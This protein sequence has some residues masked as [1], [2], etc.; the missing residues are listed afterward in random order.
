[1]NRKWFYVLSSILAAALAAAIILAVTFQNTGQDL[2]NSVSIIEHFR[3]DSESI[4]FGTDIPYGSTLEEHQAAFEKWGDTAMDADRRARCPEGFIPLTPQEQSLLNETDH[5]T[6]DMLLGD[7]GDEGPLIT[8]NIETGRRVNESYAMLLCRTAFRY[9]RK[10]AYMENGTDWGGGIAPSDRCPKGMAGRTGIGNPEYIQMLYMYTFGYVPDGL[11]DMERISETCNEI[12]PSE[13]KTGDIAILELE[14]S[15]KDF[16]VCIGAYNGYFLFAHCV[17]TADSSFPNG[18][19]RIC[20]MASQTDSYYRGSK[21]TDFTGFY[22]SP[23]RFWGN[24][25]NDGSTGEHPDQRILINISE[26]PHGND[27]V[28][29]YADTMAHELASGS[30]D[31]FLSDLACKELI[32]YGYEYTDEN[33]YRQYLDKMYE[34]IHDRD[35]LYVAF[36][37]DRDDHYN[38]AIYGLDYAGSSKDTAYDYGSRAIIYFTIFYDKE[39]GFTMLPYNAGT[40]G[41]N[42]SQYGLSC[43]PQQDTNAPDNL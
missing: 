30:P 36:V 35:Y 32:K 2:Q 5:M 21:P 24:P 37:N 28:Y 8:G 23:V 40:I 25:D 12:G 3:E 10:L 17:N 14:D 6:E 16:A 4:P 11:M 38:A 34:T 18:C 20:F 22:Q 7:E 9:N 33:A 43:I 31:K 26:K 27:A 15:R 19:A 41:Y 1:M 13:L 39:N 29:R 42:F